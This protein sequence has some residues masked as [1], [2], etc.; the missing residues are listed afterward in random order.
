WADNC[1]ENPT[2]EDI[3]TVSEIDACLA[4]EPVREEKNQYSGW[5]WNEPGSS[6]LCAPEYGFEPE[7]SVCGD[8]YQV[9]SQAVIRLEP[10]WNCFMIEEGA[11]P[12]FSGQL[13]GLVVVTSTAPHPIF[14]AEAH[15][16]RV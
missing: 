2:V 13:A 9:D 7:W 12:E 4:Q 1:H 14:C 3:D 5:N 11:S 6:N 10:G 8:E 16:P 15:E